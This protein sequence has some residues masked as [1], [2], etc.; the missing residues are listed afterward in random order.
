MV[1]K[2]YKLLLV[3]CL[4]VGAS[5]DDILDR[6]PLSQLDRTNYFNNETELRLFSNQYYKMFPKAAGIY[7]ESDDVIIVTRLKDEVN[8]IRQ[9]PEKASNENGWNFEMLRNI[10]EQLANS[11]RCDDKNV[12]ER[13]TGL[14]RFFRAY[15]Y[16]E[17]VKRFGDVPWY[18]KPLLS[19]DPDLYK[20]RDPRTL[21]MDSVI[22]DI[23]YAIEKLPAEKKIYEVTKWTALALKSRICLFEGTFRKY[24]TEFSLPDADKFLNLCVTASDAFMK[25]S[26][27]QIY[28]DGNSPY[29]TLF[30]QYNATDKGIDKEVI[31][32]R[33][34]VESLNPHSANFYA[35]NRNDG[36][37]GVNKKIINSYL[38][39]DGR[40]FTD[41]K[42][43]DKMEFYDEVK[44]RDGRLAQTIVT[45]GY[46]REGGDPSDYNDWVSP[47]LTA[48]LTGYQPVK[49]T[50]GPI[51]KYDG[52]DKSFNDIILFRAA[53]VYLNMAEAKAELDILKQSDIDET[54]QPL[55][56]RGG[57][58]YALTIETANTNPDPY[59]ENE[60]TGYPNVKGK[61]KGIILEI[62][63]Q[64][65][66]EL[67]QEGHRYYDL[68]R[69]KEGNLFT[70]SM[71]GIYIPEINAA[72][73]LDGDW[74]D[75]LCVYEGMTLA[76]AKKKFKGCLAYLKVGSDI[77]LSEGNKGN[78]LLHGPNERIR[79]WDENKDY[80]FPIPIEE[81]QLTGGKLT[82]NP[83]WND[84][85]ML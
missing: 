67:L 6:F 15:F 76:E 44:D 8:G 80:L 21:I 9:V 65:T 33:D 26:P 78:I 69:W 2:K 57:N 31:L 79:V 10:N 51:G 75:D 12:R 54:I 72:Y 82:Q 11:H 22:A 84:G 58:S 13:Y 61:N 47:N 81:R 30:T 43:Y 85:L 70:Q 35:F 20:A 17:K 74:L 4:F 62:R 46:V 68:M 66:I 73:D 42:D 19:N 24:H 41:I 36:A 28:K 32:A 5:C 45:P 16:F 52:Y 3:L 39:K 25:D 83:N 49:W 64:R 27:Y 56:D 23:D 71:L 34:Y 77:E 18:N 60:A 40:R 48:S 50:T 7:G 53:E 59:L 29:H 14:A 37:P 1:M 55:I 38:M 63:R